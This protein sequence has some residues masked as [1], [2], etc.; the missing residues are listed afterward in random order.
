MPETIITQPFFRAELPL[1]PGVN[2]SYKIVQ[3]ETREKSYRR[4][5][6]TQV[7]Q[8]FENDAAKKLLQSTIDKDV[9]YAIQSA[10]K[11]IPLHVAIRFYFPTMWRKDVDGGLKAVIDVVFRYLHLNDNLI[12]R[13]EASK[14]MD[15]KRPR[16]EVEV[17][18]CTGKK[19]SA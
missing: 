8:Q 10:Q 13:L 9:L 2:A 15:A 18:C 6:H 5:A 3:I 12:V 19:E 17:F 4:L 7:G 11:K 16:V 1:P 14:E